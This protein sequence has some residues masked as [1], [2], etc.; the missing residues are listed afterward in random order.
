[1]AIVQVLLILAF[2]PLLHGAM[3][4][5]RA[6]FSGRPGP[7]IVQPYRDLAKLWAKE[8]M[9][10]RGASPIATCA[11]GLALGVALTFAAALPEA[12]GSAATLVDVVALALV[13]ALGR[14]VLVLAA[15]GSGSAFEGM[16]A[17]REMTFAALVEPTL[18]VA[19]LGGAALGREPLLTGLVSV[20]FGP[21]GMLAA[22]AFFV[23]LL[24][25]TA[26]I[27]IDNQETHYELTMMHEGL[28]LEYSGWQLATLQVSS[29]VRQLCFFMLAALLLPGAAWWEHLLWL[30]P[31]AL[32]IVFVETLFAKVR[33]FEVPALLSTAFILAAASILTRVLGSLI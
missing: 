8:A 14:F 25:E 27:P 32:A 31:I 9:L 28:V 29:Y 10:P 17:S 15:L 19:L 4:T 3:K 5:L 18:I 12:P 30:P 22:G 7:P 23:V 13:L 6:R 11:P 24:V 33:L 20:P 21:A 2:A 16:A 26:R 1:M